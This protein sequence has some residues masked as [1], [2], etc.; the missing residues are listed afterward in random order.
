MLGTVRRN[1]LDI[2]EAVYAFE[3]DD[4]HWIS[5]LL[6]VLEPYD[7]GGGAAAYISLLDGPIRLATVE[8]RSRL[9]S[10]ESL[11][12][13]VAELPPSMYRALHVPFPTASAADR[14]PEILAAH[15]IAYSASENLAAGIPIPP[16]AWAFAGGDLD[17]TALVV[18]HSTGREPS[19]GDRSVLDAVSAHLGAAMRLRR[20]AY[21]RRADDAV[22]EGIFSA[23]GRVLDARGDVRRAETRAPLLDAVLRSERARLRGASDDE[24]LEIWTSLVEGRWSIL[25]SVERDGKRLLLACRNDPKSAPLRAL[26]PRERAVVSAAAYGHAYKF[27]AY[28]LGI[29]LST[30]AATLE[31]ALRKM[32]IPS[33]TALVTLFARAG[34]PFDLGATDDTDE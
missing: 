4:A 20:L 16:A 12:R 32:G 9:Q 30:V 18:F 10:E 31:R 15:G 3:R 1:P 14:F 11:L 24:R 21:S 22:V 29:P 17:A 8:N 26:T 34:T 7:L 23:D 2:L 33:R 13:M 28:E 5:G 25:E 27:I 19:A 6:D